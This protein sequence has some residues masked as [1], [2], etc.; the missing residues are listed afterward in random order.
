MKGAVLLLAIS[1]SVPAFAQIV[2]RPTETPIVTAQNDAW[3][4]LREPITFGGDFYYPTGPVV[5]FDGGVMVR[6][7]HYNG[8]P[9][10]ADTT[11]EPYS[12]VFVPIGRGQMQPYERVRDG[13]LAGT[14]G[15]RTSSF[16]GR[17]DRVPR[18][19]PVA[20]GSATNAPQPIGAISVYTPEPAPVAAAGRTEATPSAVGTG[21]LNVAIQPLRRG[22]PPTREN[23]SVQF[24]GRRWMADGP[25]IRRPAGLTQI[26]E[27]A[28][29]PVYRASDQND[30]QMLLPMAPG[31]VA[32]FRL[33]D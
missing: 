22:R 28:G 33:K 21:G 16:P 7:G 6:T 13:A 1:L 2:S 14:S 11:V 19:V 30:R 5:F 15:S 26:G 20:A 23:I 32:P 8:V 24:E 18:D 29:Y 31:F 3:Y 9:L 4:R 12:V 17:S 25:A 10:Y 27:Y